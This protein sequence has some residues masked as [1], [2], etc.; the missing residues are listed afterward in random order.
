MKIE[1][2]EYYMADGGTNGMPSL[3]RFYSDKNGVLWLSYSPDAGRGTVA[4]ISAHLISDKSY[5]TLMDY[6]EENKRLDYHILNLVYN[7]KTTKYLYGGYDNLDDIIGTIFRNKKTMEIANEW[8]SD[9][10]FQDL[11]S[12]DLG[13]MIMERLENKYGRNADNVLNN[14]LKDNE[15]CTDILKE[16]KK[17]GVIKRNYWDKYERN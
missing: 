15:L 6:I 9:C 14:I 8:G 2:N 5:E 3:N 10:L 11:H 12:G 7:E 16:I 17:T 13:Y 1:D 4:C